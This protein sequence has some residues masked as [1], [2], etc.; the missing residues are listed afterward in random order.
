MGVHPLKKKGIFLDRDGVINRSYIK[1]GK[2]FPPK[3]V[4][5]LDILPGV[6]GALRQLKDAG[7]LLIVVTNQPDVGRGKQKKETVDTM[8]SK[9]KS[10]LPLDDVYVCFHGQDGECGCR[11]PLPGLL[12]QAAKDNDIDLGKSYMIGD[13]WRDIDAGNIAGC[14]TFFIDYGYKEKKPD[15][16][17]FMVKSL[18]EA[19]VIISQKSKI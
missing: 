5:D 17:N 11:K 16:Y 4:S 6:R 8:H 19:S 7:F 12:L 13:R 15:S 18:N 1:D 10:Q 9:L 14:S 2:P 3:T